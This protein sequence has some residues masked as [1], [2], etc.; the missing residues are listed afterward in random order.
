M[1]T[2][3]D[4]TNRS[5][6]S[7]ILGG[8]ERL[9]IGL[10]NNMP[11]AALQTTEDQFGTLLAAAGADFD[12]RLRLFSFPELIRGEAGRKYVSDHYEPI[13]QLWTADMDGLIVTGAEPRTASM[14]DEVYWR[15]L[16][17]LVDWA[18]DTATPTIWSC[19]AAHAAVLHLDGIERHRLGEKISGLFRCEKISDH[20]LLSGLPASWPIPHSRL[21]TLR[22]TELLAA[23]YVIL[24]YSGDA[25]PDAFIQRRRTLFV[26]FQ[27]HPEYD[28]GALFREYRRDV[29]RFLAETMDRYPEMPRGYF[30]DEMTRAFKA[31]R[32]RAHQ[33]RSRDVL[34]EFPGIGSGA[35][36]SH[37]WHDAAVRLYSNWLAVVAA[38]RRS[39]GL[40]EAAIVPSP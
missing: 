16:T 11:D 40:V 24:S 6:D 17:R 19:L 1:T 26:F 2:S 10:V 7:P 30:D 34:D 23:G 22:A 33:H 4:S 20:P 27:G 8:R 35:G 21:N 25:G 31:F 37:L 38:E 14:P 18:N 29:G 36:L 39:A 28:A 12:V 15:S 3:L 5:T 32:T 9:V 13:E